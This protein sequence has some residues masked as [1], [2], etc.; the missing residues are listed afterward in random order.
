MKSWKYNRTS[1]Q[2]N[3]GENIWTKVY[4]SNEARKY[5]PDHNK[6]PEAVEEFKLLK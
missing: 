2:S 3:L 5:H 6:S 4:V 1:I